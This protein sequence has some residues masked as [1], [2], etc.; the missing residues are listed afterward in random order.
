MANPVVVPCPAN[1][2]TKVITGLTAAAIRIM[3][4]SPDKY[5]WTYIATTGA[6]PTD[7]SDAVPINGDLSL[8][9]GVSADVYVYAKGGAGEVRIDT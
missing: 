1:Q 3:S 8:S 5:L 9:F 6:A 2:W 4:N 7:F